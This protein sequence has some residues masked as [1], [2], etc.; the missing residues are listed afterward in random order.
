MI[1]AEKLSSNQMSINIDNIITK[2]LEVFKI[3]DTSLLVTVGIKM[4]TY[5]HVD[6]CRFTH[7]NR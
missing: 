6:Q 4:S 7:T 1:Y 2:T 5:S 3:T